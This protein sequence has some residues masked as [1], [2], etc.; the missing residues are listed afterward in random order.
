M[1]IGHYRPSLCPVKERMA[2]PA[3]SAA[4]AVEVI[5]FLAAH[6]N[7]AFTLSDLVDRLGINVASLHA[8]LSVLTERAYLSRHPRHLTYTLGPTLVAVGTAA[9][10]HHPAIDVAREEAKALSERL[11]LDVAVTALAGD[12]VVFVARSGGHR[13]LGTPTHVGMRTPIRAPMGS[14]FY[15]WA[16]DEA[17][18]AWLERSGPATA[19]EVALDRAELDVVRARGFSVALEGAARRELGTALEQVADRPRVRGQLDE[20]VRRTAGRSA[21]LIDID[22]E[23]SY[24][25]SSISAPVFNAAAQVALAINVVGLSPGTSGVDVLSYGEEVLGTALVVSK[26]TRGNPP[27]D[28]LA[29]A[30][31]DRRPAREHAGRR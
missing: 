2:R 28:L 15:A 12:D 27:P 1:S 31:R 8:V 16:D 20:L 14:I 24:T 18:E 23:A 5:N 6:P 13:P 3:L 17:V 4:R 30:A 10:E 29:R 19:E 26:R 25:V 21:H 11:D 22:E 9:L 7:E